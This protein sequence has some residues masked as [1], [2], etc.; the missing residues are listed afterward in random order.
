MEASI[1]DGSTLECGAVSLIKTVKHPIS[2]ARAVMEHTRHN[3][4]IGKA[5]EKLAAK[6]HLDIVDPSYFST[7]KRREQ[8]RRAKEMGDAMVNDHDYEDDNIEPDADDQPLPDP[9][10]APTLPAAR[11]GTGRPP[12]P[13]SRRNTRIDKEDPNKLRGT[14]MGIYQGNSRSRNNSENN[15]MYY[16]HHSEPLATTPKLVN[17]RRE[18][19]ISPIIAS[20]M[21]IKPMINHIIGTENLPDENDGILCTY[22]YIFM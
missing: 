4:L 1:M 20:T 7:P 15:I 12:L 2:L 17:K 21:E 14:G 22:L 11:T 5:A 8:L 10:R 13:P 18:T 3:H 6:C 9:D 16:N 19:T